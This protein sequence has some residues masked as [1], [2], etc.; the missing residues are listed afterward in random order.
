[1]RMRLIVASAA[2][3]LLAIT[4]GPANV[5]A[6]RCLDQC[7][8]AANAVAT[9]RQLVTAALDEIRRATY[10]TFRATIH[11]DIGEMSFPT[12]LPEH[13]TSH[14]FLLDGNLRAA[15]IDF[16]RTSRIFDLD[17]SHKLRS[18]LSTIASHSDA[19]LAMSQEV[20]VAVHVAFHDGSKIRIRLSVG[21]EAT[22]V[23]GSARD[24]SGH[25]LPDPN[26]GTPAYSGRWHYPPGQAADM[27]A[28][29]EYM[30]SLGVTVTTGGSAGN[31]VITCTWNPTNN[32]TTCYI[33]R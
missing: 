31:G 29:L 10:R 14:D 11:A 9:D 2:V 30:R 8:P 7:G 3:A 12:C 32:T 27:A 4:C 17:A 1:M 23:S 22:Y 19:F 13:P 26:F 18:P 15:L 5:S 20:I 16:A 25:V 28:F 6:G 33:P 21:R 24:G